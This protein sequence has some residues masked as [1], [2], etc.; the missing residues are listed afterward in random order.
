MLYLSS[1]RYSGNKRCRETG[2]GEACKLKIMILIIFTE[3]PRS[4]FFSWIRNI[5]LDNTF[6]SYS[7]NALL[8]EECINKLQMKFC[9]RIY[10]AF[11]RKD[12]TFF[13]TVQLLYYVCIATLCIKQHN[14]ATER[15]KRQTYMQTEWQRDRQ[16]ELE[17]RQG[18]EREERTFKIGRQQS[19]RKNLQ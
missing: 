3:W 13:V 4:F 14:P 16:S 2:W 12:T 5:K 15:L 11:F 1:F 10:D 8:C 9:L 7:S 6:W 19:T 17:K 18:R